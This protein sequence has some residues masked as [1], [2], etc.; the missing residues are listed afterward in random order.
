MVHKAWV[1]AGRGDTACYTLPDGGEPM[2]NPSASA[3]ASRIGELVSAATYP[4]SSTA[5]AAAESAD[6]ASAVAAA[7]AST[8]FRG[9]SAA[10]QPRAATC[11][12]ACASA[13]SPP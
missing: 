2:A 7:A 13:S 4:C 12:T 6:T 10:V 9:I 5:T 1:K 3:D 8:F 11:A